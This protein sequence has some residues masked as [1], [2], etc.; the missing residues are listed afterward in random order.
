[1][2]NYF[3]LFLL[4]VLVS[5]IYKKPIFLENISNNKLFSIFNMPK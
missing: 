5:L 3:E 4:A 1:M 2:D